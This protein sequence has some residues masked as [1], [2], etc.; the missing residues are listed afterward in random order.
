[1]ASVLANQLAIWKIDLLYLAAGAVIGAYLR[2]KIA[3]SEFY[4]AGIPLAVLSI[5]VLGSFILGIC[6]AGAQKFGLG[7]GYVLFLGVGFCGS[8]T[9][10]SSFAYETASL[11]DAG[12]MLVGFANI[13]FNVGLSIVGVFLGRALLL[14]I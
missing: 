12:R 11:M 7:D 3:G 13:I 6:M 10:M 1:M 9:T 2:Y 5:N 8:F 14:A 4:I